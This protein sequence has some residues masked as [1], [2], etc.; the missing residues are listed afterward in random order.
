[1]VGPSRGGSGLKEAPIVAAPTSSDRPI[2]EPVYLPVPPRSQRDDRSVS[3]GK[4]RS[5]ACPFCGLQITVTDARRGHDGYIRL[6]GR[7]PVPNARHD[8]F[9]FVGLYAHQSCVAIALG[10][11]ET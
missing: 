7:W 1:M 5:N 6:L 2:A 11:D 10:E 9:R 3:R 8:N 4:T